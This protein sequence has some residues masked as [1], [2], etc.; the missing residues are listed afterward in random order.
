MD[1]Q[2]SMNDVKANWRCYIML[3]PIYRNIYGR[4]TDSREKMNKILETLS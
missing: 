3:I 4:N 1:L 2:G